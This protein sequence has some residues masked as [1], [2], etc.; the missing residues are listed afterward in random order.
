[1]A[2]K[3]PNPKKSSTASG[4]GS[5]DNPA[6]AAFEAYKQRM[7]GFSW[8]AP[9]FPPGGPWA[10]YGPPLPPGGFPPPPGWMPP[11]FS[12]QSPP[13]QG[14]SFPASGGSWLEGLGTMMRLG[15]QVL[16]AA[17][18]GGLQLLEGF[19][20]PVGDEG[21]YPGYSPPGRCPCGCGGSPLPHYQ[22]HF[23]PGAA[24]GCTPSVCNC[25]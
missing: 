1:M 15:V 6:L 21:G 11:P 9:G 24:P 17:L 22:G 20:G 18:A 19:S 16:N 14:P 3:I 10:P 23:S 25:P 5:P 13:S 2:D 8:G 7:A 4:G 12:G